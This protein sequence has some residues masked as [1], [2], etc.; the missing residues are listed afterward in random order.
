MTQ[1]SAKLTMTGVHGAN[2]G[3]IQ[4]ETTIILINE[5]RKSLEHKQLFVHNAQFNKSETTEN[6]S[7]KALIAR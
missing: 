2:V 5:P 4:E 3:T 1:I 7:Q 6:L